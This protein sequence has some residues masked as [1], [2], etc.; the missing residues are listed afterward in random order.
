MKL[1]FNPFNKYLKLFW[2][3]R[4]HKTPLTK[5]NQENMSVPNKYN[6]QKEKAEK[7]IIWNL[8]KAVLM[9]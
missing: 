5:S 8:E 7:K 4:K 9:F 6:K 1:F 3:Q 2:V